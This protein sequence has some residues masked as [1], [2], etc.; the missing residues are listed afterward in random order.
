M[1]SHHNIHHK[2]EE[3]RH[4]VNRDAPG[5]EER[6]YF[7]PLQQPPA[8]SALIVEGQKSVPKLYKP[9]KIRGMTMQN[10]I[11]LSPLCQYSAEDGHYTMWHITHVSVPEREQHQH[12]HL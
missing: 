3:E 4:N 11:M 8:G 6:G 9:L 10:R 7:T 2:P 1:T 5:H 12:P